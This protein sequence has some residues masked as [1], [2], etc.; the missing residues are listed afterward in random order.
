MTTI[1]GSVGASVG[2]GTTTVRGG[3]TARGNI[4]RGLLKQHGSQGPT[5]RQVPSLRS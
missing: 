3:H 2:R 5:N 4:A 1:R